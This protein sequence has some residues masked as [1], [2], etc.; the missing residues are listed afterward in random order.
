MTHVPTQIPK[1]QQ[2]IKQVLPSDQYLPQKVLKYGG[3]SMIYGLDEVVN[4]IFQ[5]LGYRPI[6]VVSAFKGDTD[7]LIILADDCFE[8]IRPALEERL[9]Q[10]NTIRLLSSDRQEVGFSKKTF[11]RGLDIAIKYATAA[12]SLGLSCQLIY[13]IMWCKGGRDGSPMGLQKQIIEFLRDFDK[14]VSL[15][16]DVARDRA[17]GELNI[18]VNGIFKNEGDWERL[19]KRTSEIL[20]EEAKC[21]MRDK[22]V[23]WGE[24]PSSFLLSHAAKKEGKR[25][26]L[27]EA[28]DLGL[29]TEMVAGGA[30]I[31]DDANT[32]IKR[33]IREAAQR[34]Y[35]LY[36]IGGYVAKGRVV[37]DSIGLDRHTIML[38]TTLGRGGSDL[39]A[40]ACGVAL[41]IPVFL[42]SD[43][44]GVYDANPN[45]VKNPRTI[46]RLSREE[47]LEFAR[48]GSKVLYDRA[49]QHALDHEVEVWSKNTFNPLHDGTHITGTPANVG[50]PRGISFLE[51]DANYVLA[52]IGHGIGS[53][54]IE[55]DRIL[56][57]MRELYQPATLQINPHSVVFELPK[58]FVGQNAQVIY[59]RVIG[60]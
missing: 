13:D 38:R 18:D 33:K 44:D 14:Y 28:S 37:K 57:L 12:E 58:D 45:L 6:V 11:D 27:G 43:V 10:K 46:K 40:V 36:V 8:Q 30:V 24:F 25:V 1:T 22:F 16:Y 26:F 17:A 59:Q 3:S 60:S 52:V 21:Y 50:K 23:F 29:L 49:M 39:T 42:Y 7:A 15:F 55:V 19:Y 48:F 54:R 53:N 5:N 31:A 47:S 56:G 4:I 32:S 34:H 51:R 20:M 9:R 2:L 41:G 35:D